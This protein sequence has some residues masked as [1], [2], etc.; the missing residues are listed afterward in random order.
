MPPHDL[1]ADQTRRRD[2]GEGVN[3]STKELF[4]EIR[5]D[6]RAL[7][8][9]VRFLAPMAFVKEIEH[10]VDVLEKT[11]MTREAVEANTRSIVRLTWGVVVIAVG[12]GLTL[13]RMVSSHGP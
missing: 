13:W 10:R 3:F 4:V 5:A 11:S 7:G 2:D 1:T 6:L 8:N 12:W 9:D